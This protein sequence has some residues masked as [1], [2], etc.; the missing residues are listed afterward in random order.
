MKFAHFV[1]FAAEM[2]KESI[3]A[4]DAEDIGPEC[5]IMEDI[6]EALNAAAKHASD[7]D[8]ISQ[9]AMELGMDGVPGRLG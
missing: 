7:D 4:M 9:L 6:A 5:A 8:A 1:Q 3:A 2:I